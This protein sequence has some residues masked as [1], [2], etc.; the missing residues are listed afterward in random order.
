[1]G[2]GRCSHPE[3]EW[4]RSVSSQGQRP[5]LSVFSWA[6]GAPSLGAESQGKGGLPDAACPVAAAGLPQAALILT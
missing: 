4:G 5:S 1:M 3:A 2:G 6:I